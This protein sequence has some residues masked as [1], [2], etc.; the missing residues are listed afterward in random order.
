[1][2]TSALFDQ[3]QEAAAAIRAKWAGTPAAGIVLGTGLGK[4]TEDIAAAAVIPYEQIPHFPRSTAPSHKGQL[5]CGTLGGKPV[6]AMEGRFHFYEGWT[7]QQVTFPVRVMKA[8]GAQTL[9][10][11]N[12]C[13][14]MNPQWAKGDLMLIEDHIN[15][16]G[17]NPLIGPNDDRLG[18]RFPDM[19]NCYDRELLALG[20]RV[21]ME[22]QI[23]C[24]QGVFVA[25]AGP[26]LETRAEYRFLRQIGADVVGMSTVPEVIVAVHAKMR[27]MGVSVITD[28]CLPDALEPVSIPEIIKTANEAEKKLRV[29]VRRVVAEL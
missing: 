16:L 9:I 11:S 13:G 22:E 1:M 8:L 25:V 21:A 26:N 14:G 3:I 18:E 10:V 7:L 15:L 6:V 24:H 29:L 23:V 5:V 2:A 27:V 4:L 19:C 17:D 28:Q 12:A 20:K